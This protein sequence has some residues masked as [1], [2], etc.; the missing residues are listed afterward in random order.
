MKLFVAT[1][2]ALSL[3]SPALAQSA[4]ARAGGGEFSGFKTYWAQS[5]EGCRPMISLSVK[6]VSSGTI[7]PIDIRME[8]VDTDKKSKFASGS[9]TLTPADLPPGGTKNIA[10]GADQSISSR[11]CL[12]DM[13]QP[14]L[15][16]IH[17]AARLTATVSHDADGVEIFPAQPMAEER[18]PTPN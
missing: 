4:T 2:F 17:F 3:A 6:N 1:A 14:P 12:G 9:A 7:G 11:D 18:I 15:S 13:H 16:G 5:R 8:V 10:I